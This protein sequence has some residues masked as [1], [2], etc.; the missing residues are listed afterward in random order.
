MPAIAP[1][2]AWS[3][4]LWIPS[5]QLLCLVLRKRFPLK[6]KLAPLA[7]VP[8]LPTALKFK[9]RGQ[10]TELGF[11]MCHASHPAVLGRSLWRCGTSRRRGAAAAAEAGLERR[12]RPQGTRGSWVLEIL[13]EAVLLP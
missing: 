5:S 3:M 4:R 13:T 1:E 7:L 10:D 2:K 9:P 12:G 6:E 8:A 11:S